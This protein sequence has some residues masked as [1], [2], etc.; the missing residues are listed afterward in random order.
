[1]FIKPRIRRE[2]NEYTRSKHTRNDTYKTSF[3]KSEENRPLRT[4]INL[5][6][7]ERIILK[8][9]LKWNAKEHWNEMFTISPVKDSYEY[10][11]GPSGSI[12]VNSFLNSDPP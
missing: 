9:T 3:A 1:M 4:Y 12:K 8:L 7:E 11:N 2:G 6:A 5:H 10:G